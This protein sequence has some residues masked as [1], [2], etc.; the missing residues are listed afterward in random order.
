M[1][2]P[3]S[4]VV[5]SFPM[6]L[7]S[8]AGCGKSDPAPAAT[9]A[10]SASA[11][12]TGETGAP[13]GADPVALAAPFEGEIEMTMRMPA[14][15]GPMNVTYAIKG[16]K[17]RW[18]ADMKGIP[19]MWFLVDAKAN[20]SSGV[21]DAQKLIM[22]TDMT[23]PAPGA[24]MIEWKA[25]RTGKTD[26]VAGQ[27]CEIWG[28]AG[29]KN[30]AKGQPA[31]RYEVCVVN[32]ATS[33]GWLKLAGAQS[34]TH[35]AWAPELEKQGAVPLRTIGWDEAGKESVRVDTTR[36]EPKPIDDARFQLPKGYRTIAAPPL[37]GGR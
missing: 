14:L 18:D 20:K 5:L 7:A 19:K 3:S 17:A 36:F 6:L 1:R 31:Q 16:D 2:S 8:L 22:V 33:F 13:R 34:N 26:V 9:G 10:A 21:L 11:R 32:N 29:E 4:V 35:M 15:P 37:P 23:K 25:T 30:L 28:L 24:K 12:G 27:R